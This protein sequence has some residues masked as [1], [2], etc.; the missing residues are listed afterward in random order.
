[1]VCQVRAQIRA[2]GG[3]PAVVGAAGRLLS[4]PRAADARLP[5]VLRLPIALAAATTLQ[6]LVL[7]IA[8]ESQLVSALSR[9][10]P[11]SAL[12]T[13][14]S[15]EWGVQLVGQAEQP[16]PVVC[17]HCIPGKVPALQANGVVEQ[18]EEQ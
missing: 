12:S 9:Q 3:Q 1:M 10:G 14:L 17:C 4:Q 18:P 2:S 6:R 15:D 8:V 16:L 5:T 13:R 7:F 11:L